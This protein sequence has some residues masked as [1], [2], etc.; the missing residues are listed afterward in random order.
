MISSDDVR[1]LAHLSR[2]SLTDEEVEKM[3]AEIES[4]IS[5][6]DV[7]QKVKLSETPESTVYF[8]SINIMREDTA[9]HEPGLFTDALLSQAPRR[10]KNYLKVKKILG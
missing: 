1:K 9:S 10:D 2:L 4:I 7:I 5:Y 3:R 8:D 6:I